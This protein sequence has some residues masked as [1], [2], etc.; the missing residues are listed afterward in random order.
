MKR[1]TMRAVAIGLTIASCA[2]LSACGSDTTSEGATSDF[3]KRTIEMVVPYAA[4]GSTDAVTRFLVDLIDKQKLLPKRI[5][6]VNRD[7]GSGSVG[8]TQVASSKP[9]GYTIGVAQSTIVTLQPH[10]QKVAYEYD[11]WDA[12]VQLSTAPKVL[13]VKSDSPFK[14]A[15]DLIAAAKA[16]AR[17]VRV[18]QAGNLTDTDLAIRSIEDRTGAEFVRV[19]Y[20]SDAAALTALLGGSVDAQMGSGATVAPQIAAG[21]LRAL[22]SSGSKG[23][24]LFGDVPTAVDLGVGDE[25]TTNQ[26]IV[27][28]A[29]VPEDVKRVLV[30]AFVKATKSKEFAEFAKANSREV[31]IVDEAELATQLREEYDRNAS[32]EDAAGG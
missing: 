10:V 27:A 2:S 13:V 15:E 31:A 8:L 5:Q 22:V 14:T 6:I 1:R 29:G 3:P 23:S 17:S 20:E 25:I 21:K 18:S 12:L 9:D 4:G 11:S 26:M 19:P 30:D 16:K 7:G 32:F 24:K 28:P